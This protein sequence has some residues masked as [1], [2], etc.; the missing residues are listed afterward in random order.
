[1]AEKE[2]ARSPWPHYI[3]TRKRASARAWL[4]YNDD[5]CIFGSPELLPIHSHNTTATH[6]PTEE[7]ALSFLLGRLPEKF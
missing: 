3:F 5:V 4:I 7:K 2:S 1:M 6:T